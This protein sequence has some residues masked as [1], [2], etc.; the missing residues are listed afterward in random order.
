[1][2]LGSLASD[3]D[4]DTLERLNT[5]KAPLVAFAPWTSRLGRPTLRANSTEVL[6]RWRESSLAD[7]C[8]AVQVQR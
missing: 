8:L 2:R 3:G 1:M 4:E 6:K 7:Q 5:L